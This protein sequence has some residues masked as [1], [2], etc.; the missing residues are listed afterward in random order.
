MK[1]KIFIFLGIILFLHIGCGKKLNKTYNYTP[2]D[3]IKVE[4]NLRKL[5]THPKHKSVFLHFTFAVENSSAKHVYFNSGNIKAKLNEHIN[6][7]TYHDSLASTI[8]ETEELK[9]GTSIYNLYFVFPEEVGTKE[10]QNF[11]IQDFGITF[12][13][14]RKE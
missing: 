10:I 13:F 2:Y 4:I 11:E 6:E 8:A 12:D 14:K 1:L 3:S 9:Q 5:K 7:F